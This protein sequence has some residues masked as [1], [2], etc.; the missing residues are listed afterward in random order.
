[1]GAFGDQWPPVENQRIGTTDQKVGGSN[2][3]ERACLI[4]DP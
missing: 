2:P 3:S 4:A 1:L